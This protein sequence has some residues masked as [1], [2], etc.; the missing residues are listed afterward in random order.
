MS[1]QSDLLEKVSVWSIMIV[2]VVNTFSM[3]LNLCLGSLSTFLQLLQVI[4]NALEKDEIRPFFR[5]F[6]G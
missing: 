4:L 1:N 3:D 6:F 5:P 2:Q